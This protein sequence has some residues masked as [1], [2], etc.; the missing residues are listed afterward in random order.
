MALPTIA[1]DTVVE[2][3][4]EIIRCHG[5]EGS[6]LALLSEM[7][8][9]KKSSLYHRFPAGKDD[10]VKAVVLYVSAQL[11]QLV[12]APLL[13]SQVS[14]EQRF[15]DMLATITKFYH[16]GQ[17]NCLLNALSLGNGLDEIKALLAKDYHAWL[18]ALTQ[19]AKEVGMNQQEA[20][21]KAGHFLIAVQGALVIQRLTNNPLTFENCMVY[22]QKLFFMTGRN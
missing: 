4:F 3:L 5:Y 13:D 11:Q 22:E 10:M 17:K 1:Q 14:P 8:G 12:I 7:T 20:E 2:S 18:A 19:L 9:L 15:N 16:A 6:T 21:L